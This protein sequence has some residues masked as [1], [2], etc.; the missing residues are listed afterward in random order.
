MAGATIGVK[1]WIGVLTTAYA[2]QRYGSWNAMHNNYF[3]STYALVARVLAVTYPRLTIVDADWTTRQGPSNLTYVQHTSWLAASTD[4][5][6][7]SWYTAK[8]MLTPIAISPSQTNPDLPGSAYRNCLTNWVNYLRNTA[9]LPCTKDSAEISVYDRGVLTSLPEKEHGSIPGEFK[10][11]QNYPNP[12][13]PETKIKFDV[14]QSPLTPDLIGG[15]ER[16]E[17]GGFVTLKIYDI[18]GR[19]VSS[20]FSLPWERIGGATYE[21]EWSGASFPSGVYFYKLTVGSYSETKKMLLIR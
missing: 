1:N 5:A 13:N 14:P 15:T 19:E 18:L 3:F 11:Y 4:P 16:G 17:K 7:V 12:F 8:F 6:A 20:P 10:L 9:G 2:T 21:I